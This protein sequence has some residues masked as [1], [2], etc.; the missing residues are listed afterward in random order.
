MKYEHLY[1]LIRRNGW[2][3]DLD[4]S[5]WLVDNNGDNYHPLLGYKLNGTL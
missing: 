3:N 5:L 1:K 4:N 2:Q